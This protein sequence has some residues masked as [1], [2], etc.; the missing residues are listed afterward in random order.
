MRSAEPCLISN[1]M[2]RLDENPTK[3]LGGLAYP[4]LL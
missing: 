1:V 4:L 2:L 3:E